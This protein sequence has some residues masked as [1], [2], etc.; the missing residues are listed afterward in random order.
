MHRFI[1][2]YAVWQ[3]ARVTEMPVTHHARRFGKSHYGLE[4]M[5]KVLLDLVVVKFFSA[6]L[7]KPIYVFG[8]FGCLSIILSFLSLAAA[9]VFKLIP[10]DNPWGEHWHKDLIQTPLPVLAVGFFA[11][12]VMM[13]LIGLLAEMLMRTYYESQHKPVYLIGS[14]KRRAPET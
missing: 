9:L 1:P 14:I 7:T 11:V 8:G 12:G 13:T 6:Y 5:L 4:R 10:R 2:I 3:G